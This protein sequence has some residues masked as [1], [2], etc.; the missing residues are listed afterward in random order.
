MNANK[1][2]FHDE[3]WACRRAESSQAADARLDEDTFE[4]SAQLSCSLCLTVHVADSA[5][6]SALSCTTSRSST[7]VAECTTSSGSVCLNTITSQPSELCSRSPASG[8]SRRTRSARLKAIRTPSEASA[9]T[10]TARGAL[11]VPGLV[12]SGALRA[13]IAT[14]KGYDVI[15]GGDNGLDARRA[16]HRSHRARDPRQS[17]AGPSSAR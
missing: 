6:D 8:T 12:V 15:T 13:K 9:P 2:N 16:W 10:S 3:A 17:L 5:D 7:L 14:Q 11:D 1:G 4:V